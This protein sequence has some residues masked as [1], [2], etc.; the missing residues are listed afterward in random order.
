MS[1]LLEVNNDMPALIIGGD[2]GAIYKDKKILFLIYEATK[3]GMQL[4][5]QVFFINY[6]LKSE[7][8]T[9]IN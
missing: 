8:K 4:I 1:N 6:I 2:C 5:Q 3:V 7:L 9:I